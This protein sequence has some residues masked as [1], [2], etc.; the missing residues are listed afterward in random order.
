MNNSQTQLLTLLLEH[1]VCIC[2]YLYVCSSLHYCV[3]RLHATV[4]KQNPNWTQRVNMSGSNLKGITVPFLLHHHLPHFNR[5]MQG[6]NCDLPR[7]N[8]FQLQPL[9]SLQGFPAQG[10][11]HLMVGLAEE[12]RRYVGQ[13]MESAYVRTYVLLKWGFSLVAA[14]SWMKILPTFRLWWSGL[15]HGEEDLKRTRASQLKHWQDFHPPSSWYQ[16]SVY[17]KCIAAMEYDHHSMMTTHHHMSSKPVPAHVTRH[18]LIH[19]HSFYAIITNIA[20]FS[21]NHTVKSANTLSHFPPPPPP[22]ISLPMWHTQQWGRN[23]GQTHQAVSH[24]VG[25]LNNSSWPSCPQYAVTEESVH[26]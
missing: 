8:I 3:A 21:S 25:L 1:R 9:C 11:D 2:M 24:F 7:S 23:W 20:C 17:L 6:D 16:R 26:S 5:W 4:C 13:S 14:W 19:V 15:L 18:K 12:G 22:L 10:T